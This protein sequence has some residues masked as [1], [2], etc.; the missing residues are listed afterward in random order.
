MD[1]DYQLNGLL[2]YSFENGSL[3][4][5]PFQIDPELGHI[6]LQGTLDREQQDTYSVIH[7]SRTVTEISLPSIGSSTAGMS[8]NTAKMIFTDTLYQMMSVFC[9]QLIVTAAD[10]RGR[11]LNVRR[12]TAPFTVRVLDVNDSIPFFVNSVSMWYSSRM[13]CPDFQ[14]TNRPCS[15]MTWEF[16]RATHKRWLLVMCKEMTTTLDPM[17]SSTTTFLEAVSVTGLQWDSKQHL[18]CFITILINHNSDVLYR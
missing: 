10:Q 12:T 3:L 5:G 14:Y 1:P 2:A 8:V 18:A 16:L 15:D 17:L 13:M 9:L 6:T 4:T 11:G 7:C